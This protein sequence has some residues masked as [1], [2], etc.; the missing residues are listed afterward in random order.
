MVMS[1]GKSKGYSKKAIA[2]WNKTQRDI[3]KMSAD[4]V[5]LEDPASAVAWDLKA[6]IARLKLEV[7]KPEFYLENKE[8]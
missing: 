7:N 5:D 3:K 6:D 8:A 1:N 4:Y 2:L